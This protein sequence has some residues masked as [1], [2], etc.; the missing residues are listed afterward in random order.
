M[1]ARAG[2]ASAYAPIAAAL[3]YCAF[4]APEAS[5]GVYAVLRD[6]WLGNDSIPAIRA[7]APAPLSPQFW[8]TFWQLLDETP[9]MDALT[10]TSRV[11]ALG[12][13]IDP[14]L[15][16]R[17]EAVAAH[18]PKAAQPAMRTPPPRLTIDELARQPEGSL[19]NDFWRLIIDNKFDLE[20]LDRETISLSSLPPALCYLNTRILQM[21]DVWHLAGGFHTT[22]LHEIAISAFQ[23]A[24]FGHGYSAMFLA[25]VTSRMAL[26]GSE[27][28]PAVLQTIAEA[29]H[30]GADC[31]SFM[32]IP[33]EKEWHEPLRVIRARY[34]FTAFKG[35]FPPD[36]FEQSRSAA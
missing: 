3:A 33:W 9:A 12:A 24:Q 15:R 2:D 30:Y 8:T 1:A 5:E 13:L 32:A 10:V 22:A 18:H 28:V 4:A 16:G 14:S 6:G 25:V 34:G 19:G 29:S 21:H 35:S 36:L 20:V 11:A 31:P 26:S 27:A 23:L 7:V 17:A